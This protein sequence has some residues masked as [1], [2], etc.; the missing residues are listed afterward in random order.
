MRKTL[1]ACLFA[2]SLALMSASGQDLAREEARQAVYGAL[3]Q[4]RQSLSSAPFGRK[5]IAILPIPGDSSALI[6]GRLKNLVTQC[7]FTCVEGKSDPMWNEIIK[8]IAWDER[9]DDILDPSTLVKFGK[10]KAAQILLYGKV[11][12]LSQNAD[13]VY[14]EVEL[15][16][17]DL[18][19]KQ[20]I[21]GGNFA[22]RSYTA[23]DVQGIVALD[24]NV[25]LLL[26]KN[27]EAAKAALLAPQSVSK[28]AN[29]RHVTVIP[30]A[31]DIDQYM[32]GL[33]I[34]MLTQ[35]R[36]LPKNPQIPSL[37]EVRQ[38]IRNGQLS[39][40]AVFYGAVR[41]LSRRHKSS[42]VEGKHRKT[43]FTYN[44][45]IQLFLED[46]KTG[47]ILW[48]KTVTLSEDMTCEQEL[49]PAEQKVERS[50]RREQRQE[51]IK[52]VPNQMKEDLVDN[53][54][55]YL[56]WTGIVIG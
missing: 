51:K 46:A 37:A 19:T 34:E 6:T 21:W 42:E 14:A 47:N 28:L 4:A 56:M 18:A 55:T 54:K 43:V 25:R 36:H 30:L 22:C 32:S 35:T 7:N 2:F 17:T 15:H 12:V 27:F 39:S 13:R 33:A 1:L 5:T 52:D 31:G 41:D 3:E 38:F 10:L 29:I 50:L 24:N 40:D 45:D 49:T 8:E 44:I 16:A 48:S 23:K 26:K 9:K 11:R 20:H 53:W